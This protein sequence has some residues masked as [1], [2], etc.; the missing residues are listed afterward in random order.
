MTI[1]QIIALF[2]SIGACL[3]ALAALWAVQEMKRQRAA[4][5][6]PEL[7]LSQ[8]IFEGA[9][10]VKDNRVPVSWIQRSSSGEVIEDSGR[11][12]EVPLRNVGLGAAKEVKALWSFPIS[13]LVALINDIAQRT[14]TPLYITFESEQ[15]HIKSEG[16]INS[17]VMTKRDSSE[18]VDYVLPLSIQPNPIML[19]LPMSYVYL[20]S[21]LIFLTCKENSKEIEIPDIKLQLEYYDIA[22]GKHNSSLDLKFYLVAFGSNCEFFNAYLK[23]KKS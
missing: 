17:I 3:A 1:D 11:F 12:F 23:P 13:E 20:T 14:M 6:H 19:K 18:I 2:S 16:L 15:L 22:N 7:V 10:S 4:T 5:Y 9:G 8:K 21:I